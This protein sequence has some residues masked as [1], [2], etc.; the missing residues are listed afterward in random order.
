M[1]SGRFVSHIGELKSIGRVQYR[2]TGRPWDVLTV[3]LMGAPL[4]HGRPFGRWAESTSGV[5]RSQ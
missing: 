1:T 3:A 2:R 4:A 5:H